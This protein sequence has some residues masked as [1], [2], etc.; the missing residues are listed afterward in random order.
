MTKYFVMGPFVIFI[1]DTLKV[2]VQKATVPRS[3]PKSFSLGKI[4]VM[5]LG[6]FDLQKV[7]KIPL[8]PDVGD[9]GDG[10]MK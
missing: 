3:L 9:P 4:S 6:L 2:E 8:S 10:K 1:Q 7:R 5:C